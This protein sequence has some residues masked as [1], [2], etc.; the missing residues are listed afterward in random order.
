MAKETSLSKVTSSQTCRRHWSEIT[1]VG[2]I[3]ETIPGGTFSPSLETE[4]PI[5]GDLGSEEN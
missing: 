2:R 1:N 3:L 5:Y 4:N